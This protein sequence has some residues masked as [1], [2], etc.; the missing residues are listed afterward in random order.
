MNIY[1]FIA[2]RI[3]KHTSAQEN[4]SFS[5][6]IS[7]VAVASIAFSLAVLLVAFAVLH[8]FSD[9]IKARVFSFSGHL[10]VVMN[11]ANQSVE[12]T[13]IAT[14][15]NIYKIAKTLDY[16]SHVQYY[17]QKAGVIKADKE[18][19]GVVVKGL[20]AD[21]R[22]SDFKDNIKQ[23]R[24]MR[25]NGEGFSSEVVISQIIADK[26][27][28]S[29]GDSIRMFF[30]Q[31]PPKFRKLAIV[32]I[33]ESNM[34]TFDDK[35]ILADMR[36]LQK[37]NDW[38]DTLVSGYEVF[39][40]DFDKFNENLP[41]INSLLEYDTLI[42]P[43][44]QKHLDIFDWLMMLDQNVL[45]LLII[46]LVVASLNIF[47]ILII[48]MTER[49]KMIGMLKAMGT[50]TAQVI[51]IFFYQGLQITLKGIFWGN[52]I[53][54]GFCAVQ[55]FTKIIAL[56][57]KNYYMNSVPI[58]WWWQDILGVN[59]GILLIISLAMLLPIALVSRIRPIKAI[60]FD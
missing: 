8:G 55:Y 15:R 10:R 30:V 2:L 43:I 53:G 52:L 11:S 45:I 6:T 1:R 22:F 37:V 34:E 32:G 3:S 33:Y 18:V 41:K 26:L 13:P 58:S 5:A 50:T 44:A 28:L 51:R 24:F 29:V 19:L 47:S 21:Y 12:E 56:D 42:V 35:F 14:T 9:T 4:T 16:V 17:V 40:K 31:N 38:K 49:I 60:K 48:L 59:L 54:L 46:I 27:R 7:K 57:A 23:G 39:F 20:G 36:M 25:T